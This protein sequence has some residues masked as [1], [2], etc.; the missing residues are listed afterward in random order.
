MSPVHE[1]LP[2]D[3]S[4]PALEEQVLAR[5][6]ERDVFR[7]TLR[8]REGAPRFLFYE[9]PPTA[10][11]YP[12]S[13]HVLARVFKDVFPRYK[14]MTGHYVERKAGWDTHGLPVEIAVEQQLGFKSKDD[15]ERYGIAEFNRKCREAVLE[16]LSDWRALTERIAYW[17]DLDDA[18][19]TFE[20]GYIESVWWALAR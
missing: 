16:H 12:G 11:G 10:N 14:T 20:P 9:G 19:Y 3:V 15:I 13:H 6:R 1:P 18:Y 4:F 5:W 7:A 2:P 17:V 8:N